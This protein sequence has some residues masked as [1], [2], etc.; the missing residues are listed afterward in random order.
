MTTKKTN[1]FDTDALKG[2]DSF[3]D[4]GRRAAKAKDFFDQDIDVHTAAVLLKC[5]VTAL[6]D[7]ARHGKQI[8]GKTIPA[9]TL[10]NERGHMFFDG[11]EIKKII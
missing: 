3:G 8:N 7:A 4:M 2:C 6:K 5:S 1:F 10:V 9:P 11:Q